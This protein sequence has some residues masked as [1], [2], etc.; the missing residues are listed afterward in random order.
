[1]RFQSQAGQ[2]LSWRLDGAMLAA[3]DADFAW[4]PAPGEHELDL[5]DDGGRVAA[6]TQFQV[7][8]TAH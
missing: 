6:S 1:V 4:H 5:V 3:A 2:G 7:R 8:G